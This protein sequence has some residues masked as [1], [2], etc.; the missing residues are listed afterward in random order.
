MGFCYN[1]N[2]VEGGD[3]PRNFYSRTRKKYFSSAGV[4]FS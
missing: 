4:N 1:I 2:K 3:S